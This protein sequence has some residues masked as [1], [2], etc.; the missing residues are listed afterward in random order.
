VEQQ[1][2]DIDHECALAPSAAGPRPIRQR[3][4]GSIDVAADLRDRAER[5]EPE[6]VGPSHLGARCDAIRVGVQPHRELGPDCVRTRDDA[7]IVAAQQRP[8]VLRQGDEPVGSGAALQQ[9]RPDTEEL[10]AVVD[11]T[12]AIAVE[13]Q[14]RLVA[15]RPHPLHV[16]G[17]PVGIDVERHACAGRTKLDAVAARVD[18][19]RAALSPD[20]GREQAQKHTDE[21]FHRSPF[22][23]ES[24]TESRILACSIADWP[25]DRHR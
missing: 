16:V 3:V 14:E 7:V 13:R 22:L 12:V 4:A 11:Q 8:I 19:D 21:S 23:F 25:A 1:E 10:R 15:A 2:E 9:R 17:E 20:V 5:R 24:V 6:R 18:Y